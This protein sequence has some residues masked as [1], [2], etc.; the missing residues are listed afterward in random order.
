MRAKFGNNSGHMGGMA[1]IPIPILMVLEEDTASVLNSVSGA[2]SL[3]LSMVSS[4]INNESV[5]ASVANLTN[6]ATSDKGKKKKRVDE[7]DKTRR[8]RE[9]HAEEVKESR[10]CT[11]DG[12]KESFDDDDDNEDSSNK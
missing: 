4:A 8:T 3:E 9:G 1:A 10:Q 2:F 12:N 11:R 5:R 7:T 6:T